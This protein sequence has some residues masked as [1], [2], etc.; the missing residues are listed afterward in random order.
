MTTPLDY[1]PPGGGPPWKY[2]A[3]AI[4]G[5]VL[6]CVASLPL[7][8][9]DLHNHLE[10]ILL[11]PW[12]ALGVSALIFRSIASQQSHSYANAAFHQRRATTL[13]LIAGLFIGGLGAAGKIFGE[14]PHNYSRRQVRCA[15]NLKQIGL[16]MLLY[17]NANGRRYPDTLDEL[18]LFH[19]ADLPPELFVCPDTSDTPPAGTTPTAGA[20][21]L[22][23]GGQNSY[24]Y[25]GRGLGEG[26][27]TEAILAHERFGQHRGRGINVLFGDLHVE[28]VDSEEAHALLAELRA[29]Y[30]PPRRVNQRPRAP[31][32]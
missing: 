7:I 3:L 24:V 26:V 1:E 29:G 15:S 30:N 17:G 8:A 25:L 9:P 32:D 5:A 16:A 4:A 14:D 2:A 28:F 31:R 20:A 21:D 6:F 13:L 12:L 11:L 10:P 22:S 18:A 23:A 27:A 19:G